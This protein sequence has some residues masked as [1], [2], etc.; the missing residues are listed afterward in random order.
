MVG[1]SLHS[2][3]EELYAFVKSIKPGKIS[4]QWQTQRNKLPVDKLNQ[5]QLNQFQ[6]LKS[7]K[8][9]GLPRLVDKFTDPEK[10]SDEYRFL[11]D[12]ENLI[13]IKKDLG[14]SVVEEKR[15]LL[16]LRQE[17]SV[18]SHDNSSY[19]FNSKDKIRTGAKMN[20][21]ELNPYLRAKEK[22]WITKN[23][24]KQSTARQESEFTDT[25]FLEER[26]EDYFGEDA[27][28]NQWKDLGQGEY[29]GF[30]KDRPK[31]ANSNRN[32]LEY[33]PFSEGS[34]V[35]DAETEGTKRQGEDYFE[36]EKQE[37]ILDNMEL[38][39]FPEIEEFY[40]VILEKVV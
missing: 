2:N 12:L 35:G 9:S 29:Y 36:E 15:M 37:E 24:S 11:L 3:F 4:T 27:S 28:D 23:G 13:T 31:L 38:E 32:F 7:F 16:A 1:Y 18:D 30:P 39:D 10:L 40:E 22:E 17:D 21:P 19:I 14:L 20:Q 34:D 8:Q 25:Q 6:Y 33:V 26:G 5:Q